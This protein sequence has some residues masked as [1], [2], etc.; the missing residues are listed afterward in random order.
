MAHSN[1][2]KN[3]QG[4]I[5]S[6]LVKLN[7]VLHEIMPHLSDASSGIINKVG[8]ASIVTGGTNA[9]VTT[10]IKTQ[11]PTWLTVSNLTGLLSAIG[12]GV[13][14]INVIVRVVAYLY[15]ARRK[16]RRE[17]EEHDRKIEDK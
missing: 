2:Y 14:I 6:M 8:L 16:D 4:K 3:E 10:A 12:A 1:I 15:F 17:Q 7:G 9:V 13:F 5:S 11:D